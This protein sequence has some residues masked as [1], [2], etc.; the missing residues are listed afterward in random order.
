MTT[1][2][3]TS[4]PA[5]GLYQGGKFCSECGASMAGN[6]QNHRQ[7]GGFESG[8]NPDDSY[9][10]EDPM[11]QDYWTNQPPPPDDFSSDLAGLA[12]LVLGGIGVYTI[13]KAIA[14]STKQLEGE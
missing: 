9:R 4:C 14:N 2:T 12:L 8:F 11:W 5:C 7:T 6:G 3:Y 1:Q 13:V 10:P